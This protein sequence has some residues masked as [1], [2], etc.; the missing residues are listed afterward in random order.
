MASALS[1]ALAPGPAPVPGPVPEAALTMAP[2]DRLCLTAWRSMFVEGA[3]ATFVNCPK[4]RTRSAR[5]AAKAAKTA[6]EATKA[7]RA[8][9]AKALKAG[10]SAERA[11]AAGKRAAQLV[12][13]VREE[14]VRTLHE[15][16]A[17][18]RTSRHGPFNSLPPPL[19]LT[20]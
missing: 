11:E 4:Q 2:S 20:R 6:E 19:T 3:P 9:E 10:A 14:K 13:R 8:A 1:P 18:A 15:G 16:R 5:A 7:A 17:L 12:E